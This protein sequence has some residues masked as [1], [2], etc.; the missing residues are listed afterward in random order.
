MS[1]SEP[2]PWD[3]EIF[4]ARISPHRSLTS[5]GFRTL[6]LVFSGA[7]ALLCIPFVLL[8][9]W[10]IA[11]YLLLDVALFGSA[12]EANRRAA[13]AYETVRLTSVELEFA[14]VTARGAKTEWRFNP[15]WVRIERQEH[16][17]FG[18]ERLSLVSR[19]R[20][21]E[22]AGFLGP[23]QKAEFADALARALAVARG[24]VRF[25]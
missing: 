9:A 19:G 5:R 24:G 23:G 14:R 21:V 6:V 3:Q 18:L 16:E 2:D 10:P 8:G 7:S 17:E 12:L 13:H 1:T 15:F 4:A 20:R 22:I 25:T 11:T